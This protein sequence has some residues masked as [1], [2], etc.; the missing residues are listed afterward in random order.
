M[1]SSKETVVNKALSGAAKLPYSTSLR[2]EI[3]PFV[4]P[5][6][7]KIVSCWVSLEDEGVS[8]I[9]VVVKEDAWD[10]ISDPDKRMSYI[11]SLVLGAI[12]SLLDSYVKGENNAV[13]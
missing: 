2:I 1:P 8:R 11:N 10:R 12:G 4:R 7:R 5:A 6:N 3:S 9:E 13:K